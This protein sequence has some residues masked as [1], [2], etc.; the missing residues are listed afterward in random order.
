MA[1]AILLG[2]AL[3]GE[4]PQPERS[5]SNAVPLEHIFTILQNERRRQVLRYLADQD[6]PVSIS[7]LS[8]AVAA[9]EN[10]KSVRQITSQERKRVYV[11]LYQA[12]LP[13]MADMGFIKFNKDRGII[14]LGPAAEAAFPYLNDDVPQRYN[15]PIYYLGLV[16][17]GWVL[18]AVSFLTRLLTPLLA[19]GVFLTVL[20][21]CA[22]IHA[23]LA[24][25]NRARSTLTSP[26]STE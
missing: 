25:T 20:T 15:W 9:S 22:L 11:G 10:G 19:S 21:F 12:H 6:G 17:G 7:D 26:A 24:R 1:I 8:E 14:D 3:N 23:Y 4:V 18:L 2:D 16:G 5:D 13:K